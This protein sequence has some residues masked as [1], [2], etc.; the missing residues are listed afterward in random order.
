MASGIDFINLI[1]C[2]IKGTVEPNCWRHYLDYIIMKCLD[3][4]GVL[5]SDSIAGTRCSVVIKRVSS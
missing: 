3:Y 5:I 2:H 4:R 1:T